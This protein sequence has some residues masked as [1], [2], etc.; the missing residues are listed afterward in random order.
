MEEDKVAY[1]TAGLHFHKVFGPKALVICFMADNLLADR[2]VIHM[3]WD[4][5]VNMGDC[6]GQQDLVYDGSWFCSRTKVVLTL[7]EG[8]LRLVWGCRG[9]VTRSLFVWMIGDLSG[10]TEKT[11]GSVGTIIAP[12]HWQEEGDFRSHVQMSLLLYGLAWVLEERDAKVKVK[13]LQN[14]K[15]YGILYIQSF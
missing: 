3:P 9:G 8:V 15:W 13:L 6:K 14:A 1:T 4:K 7:H 2:W 12:K 10:K 11:R 5:K